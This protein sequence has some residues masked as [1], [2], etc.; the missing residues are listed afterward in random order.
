VRVPFL[1]GLILGAVLAFA[2]YGIFLRGE[3]ATATLPDPVRRTKVKPRP[4]VPAV[5]GYTGSATCAECHPRLFERWEK[6]GHSRAIAPF[7][8]EFVGKPFDGE[9]F[10]A[11]DIDH[12]LGP[13]GTMTCEGPGGEIGTFKVDSVIGVRRIQMFTTSMPGGRIQV[14]PV[15]LEVPKKSWFDYTDFIFGGPADFDV[16][17]DSPNSW[18]TFA[19]NFN[20][21]C[22]RCHAT[23][24][25]IGYDADTGNYASRWN[26]LA[27]GCESCHGAGGPHVT[28]WRRLADGPDP[29]VNPARLP[30]DRANMVCGQCHSESA[31]I[32]PRYKPGDDL[33][34]FMDLAGLEDRK[35]VHPDGRAKEL[36]HNLVPILESR[37]GPIAC[38]KCHDAHGSGRLGDLYRPLSDD[39]TCTQCHDDIGAALT[40]HTHHKAESEGS[41]CVACHMPK[42]VIEGGHG[43]TYDHT[44]STPSIVNTEN[45]KL[46]NACQRCHLLEDPEWEYEPFQRWYPDAEKNNHRVPL[47]KAIAA[48]R[49]KLPEAKP[50]LEALLKDDNPVYRAGAAWLLAT[51]D[52][53]LRSALDDTSSLVRRAAIEGVKKTHPASLEPLLDSPNSV[54]RY[55]AAMALAEREARNRADLRPRVIAVLEEFAGLRPDLV[56][57]HYALA[58]LYEAAGVTDKAIAAYRRCS[59]INPWDKTVQ[60]KIASLKKK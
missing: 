13:G 8:D 55:R 6:T 51:Y 17:P 21:R 2:G 37:C 24:Y 41:R 35:H 16:P 26:E 11:R 43:W 48:G 30:T 3:A 42:M 33:F 32:D 50:L 47:A 58:A 10:S 36:I 29:M 59:R 28:K 15:M 20:S 45:L 54:L 22:V 1:T 44:I 40:E 60:D 49:D 7:S 18:Y 31:M 9:V 56:A 14:L 53:D 38:T 4:E 12:R 46:P 39:K 23:D 19:R 25:E 5:T 34:A 57:T 52:V 27:V